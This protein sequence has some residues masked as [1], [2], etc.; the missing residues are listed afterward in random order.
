MSE[1]IVHRTKNIT[2]HRETV[3]NDK[4][5]KLSKLHTILKCACT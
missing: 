4:R 2:K 1:K 3:Q 5:S